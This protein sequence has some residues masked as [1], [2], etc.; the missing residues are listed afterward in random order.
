[1]VEKQVMV[2]RY[3]WNE[4]L[5]GKRVS[6][7]ADIE[8]TDGSLVRGLAFEGDHSIYV[9]VSA[10][11]MKFSGKMPKQWQASST[12]MVAMRK[13]TFTIDVESSVRGEKFGLDIVVSNHN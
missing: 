10:K 5:V 9:G 2:A 8:F 4:V 3:D 7:V 13:A 12:H 1:M 11:S 6:R